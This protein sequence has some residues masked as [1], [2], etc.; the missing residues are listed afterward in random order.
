[1]AIQDSGSSS[2]NNELLQRLKIEGN[3]AFEECFVILTCT[4]CTT[5]IM[6]QGNKF[7]GTTPTINELQ[8]ALQSLR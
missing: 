4:L 3:T 8:P 1:M 6:Q 2:G 5:G 7:K